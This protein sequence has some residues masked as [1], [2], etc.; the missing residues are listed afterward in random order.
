MAFG[1]KVRGCDEPTYIQ[2]TKPDPK[3]FHPTANKDDTDPIEQ[4]HAAVLSPIADSPYV[5]CPG[6]L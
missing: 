6:Y 4:S 2:C 3:R 5:S 1:P